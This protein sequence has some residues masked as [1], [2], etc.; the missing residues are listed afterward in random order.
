MGVGIDVCIR[1]KMH[2]AEKLNAKICRA[3]IPSLN[4][5]T[6]DPIVAN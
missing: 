4:E 2:G 1:S 3:Y 6:T 5:R